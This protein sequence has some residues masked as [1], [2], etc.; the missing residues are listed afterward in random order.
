MLQEPSG[1]DIGIVQGGGL[2]LFNFLIRSGKLTPTVVTIVFN[3]P[4]GEGGG[5]S[6]IAPLPLVYCLGPWK[7]P[8]IFIEIKWKLSLNLKKH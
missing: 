2:T 6:P 4:V 7:P 1:A 5:L 3:L 8:Y